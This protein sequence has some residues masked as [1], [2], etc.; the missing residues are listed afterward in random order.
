MSTKYNLREM[1]DLNGKGRKKYPQMFST[2]IFTTDQI[3]EEISR[4]CSLTPSDIKGALSALSQIISEK[5]AN[6]YTVKLDD[7]G[8]FSA[9]LSLKDPEKGKLKGHRPNAQSI[10]IGNIRFKADKRLVQIANQYCHLER[11]DKAFNRSS[12][13]Y[14][15]E[16]RLALAHQY[17]SDHGSIRVPQYAQ[18][19]GLAPTTATRELRTIAKS[20]TCGLQA[21][22]RGP[23]LHYIWSE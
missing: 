10:E 5:T 8:L 14:T 12:T 18:I 19:T 16:E 13:Q 7:I 1:N 9:T 15:Q 22:G 3:A 6:G 23:L 4:H 2:G 20:K 21:V 17:I 11:A